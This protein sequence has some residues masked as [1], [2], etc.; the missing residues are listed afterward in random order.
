MLGFPDRLGVRCE[1]TRTLVAAARE[2]G[3]RTADTTN[4]GIVL[5]ILFNIGHLPTYN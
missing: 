1:A 2:H 4:L 5:P 3:A